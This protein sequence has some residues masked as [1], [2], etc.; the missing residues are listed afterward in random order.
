M[1]SEVEP[2]HNE[3]D[4]GEQEEED[5]DADRD[6]PLASSQAGLVKT[7]LLDGNIAGLEVTVV[8]L[9]DVAPFYGLLPHGLLHRSVGTLLKG[10]T[11]SEARH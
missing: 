5:H 7:L 2:T 3:V 10:N 8:L 4:Q 1:A 6:V 11:S 9:V